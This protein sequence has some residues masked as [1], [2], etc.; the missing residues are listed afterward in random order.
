MGKG[1]D[2]RK[3]YF[4]K[5]LRGICSQA[6]RRI[7]NGPVEVYKYAYRV[8]Y[9]VRQ[10]DDDMSDNY[11]DKGSE[12]SYRR[13]CSHKHE[14]KRDRRD[15][16]RACGESYEKSSSLEI[17]FC[18]AKRSEH[19]DENIKPSGHHSHFYTVYKACGE[20]RMTRKNVFIP[21]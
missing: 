11:F 19:S 7:L 18:Y 14:G 13:R 6:C 2:E 15:E 10:N 17:I 8:S 1:L 3:R 21:S 20:V 16:H 5:H 4:E 12:H 9:Y